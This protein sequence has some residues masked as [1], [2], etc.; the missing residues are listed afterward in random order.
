MF[1]IIF[2]GIILNYLGLLHGAMLFWY[3]F[4]IILKCIGFFIRVCT[5]SIEM[6]LER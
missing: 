1:S 3:I 6:T 2:I 5:K 4:W